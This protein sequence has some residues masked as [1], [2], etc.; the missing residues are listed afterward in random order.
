M[1]KIHGLWFSLALILVGCAT[2]ESSAHFTRGT[3]ALE[4]SDY[5]TAVNELTEAVRLEPRFSRYHTNLSYAHFK[6]NDVKKG[7]YH[8]RQAVLL[9]TNNQQ[10]KASFESY[11]AYLERSGK[12]RVG[13]LEKDVLRALD[14]PDIALR[15]DAET[16]YIWGYK[17]VRVKGA[18]VVSIDSWVK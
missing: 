7:W 3:E 4:R 1:K 9:D 10:A 12:V 13:S 17:R 16:S 8:L 15:A 14:E 5:Q 2:V 18:A 11:W 6:L